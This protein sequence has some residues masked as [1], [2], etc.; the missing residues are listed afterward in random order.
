MLLLGLLLVN[1]IRLIMWKPAWCQLDWGSA[2]GCLVVL[3][4]MGKEATQSI[5]L[6]KM[7]TFLAR[8]VCVLVFRDCWPIVCDS[9]FLSRM[10]GRWLTFALA[11]W[12]RNSLPTT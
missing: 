6:G 9:S 4:M 12:R 11:F 10:R 3:V 5:P 2:G 8:G 1:I 7:Q